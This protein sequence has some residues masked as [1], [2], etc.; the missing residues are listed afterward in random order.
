MKKLY[1][2]L[3][4]ILLIGFGVFIYSSSY[5]INDNEVVLKGELEKFINRGSSVTKSVDIKKI[6]D[7][8]NRRY[9]LFE[10]NN[11]LGE[12]ELGRGFNGKYKIL[13]TGYGT[14]HFRYSIKDIRNSKYFIV[15]GENY[16]MKISYINISID[17]NQYKMDVP[18]EDYFIVFHEVP[19]DTVEQI[20]SYS[21]FRLYDTNNID[22][23]DEIYE[24]LFN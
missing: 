17:E 24:K 1:I 12:A 18:Q 7:I 22:I 5:T 11:E 9:V 6:L 21:D 10:V 19:K 13:S 20:P 16:D 15:L 8:E 14:K 2:I 3:S 23:S 4:C